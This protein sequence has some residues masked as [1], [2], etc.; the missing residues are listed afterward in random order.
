MNESN[1]PP[2]VSVSDIPGNRPEDDAWDE[3]VESIGTDAAEANMTDTDVLVAWRMGL[4]A[5]KAAR[6]FG[7]TFPHDP[8]PE[9]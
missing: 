3:L 9:P 7:P 5:Y 6:G 4:A 2:G 1:L 8:P